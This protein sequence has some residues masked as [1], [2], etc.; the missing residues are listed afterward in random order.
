VVFVLYQRLA[1]SS[2][3]PASVAALRQSKADPAKGTSVI[4]TLVVFRGIAER[5]EN[6]GRV[7]GRGEVQFV[8]RALGERWGWWPPRNSYVARFGCRRGEPPA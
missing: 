3:F 4:S 8:P 1:P 2:L 6:L 5:V 7:L